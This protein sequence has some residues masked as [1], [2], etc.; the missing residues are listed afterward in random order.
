MIGDRPV[1]AGN[2]QCADHT[3]QYQAPDDA[4]LDATCS[5]PAI[6][7]FMTSIPESAEVTPRKVMI[8]TTHMMVMKATHGHQHLGPGLQTTEVLLAPMIAPSATIAQVLRS[9]Y[10]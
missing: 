10:R 6:M 3:G 9:A 7:V 8:N 1:A 5:P 2:D 4:V